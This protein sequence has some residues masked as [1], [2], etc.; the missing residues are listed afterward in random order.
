MRLRQPVALLTA[1]ACALP[2]GFAA[3]GTPEPKPV[4]VKDFSVRPMANLAYSDNRLLLHPKVLVGLGYD[5]NVYAETRDEN[6]GTFVRGLVGVL[7]DYRINPHQSLAIDGEFETKTYLKEENDEGDLIGGR[8]ALDYRWQEER[9]SAGLH[10]GYDRFNDPLIQTGEQVLRQ[11][12]DGN[13]SGAFSTSAILSVVRIGVV[14][15]DYLEDAA[16][17][18]EQSRDNN[19]I[20]ATLRI[21]YSEARDTF[22]YALIGYESVQYDEDT[23]FNSSNGV[24]GGVGLQV[25]LGER[26]SLTAEGGVTYRIYD[27]NFAGSTAWDDEEVLAPY[28]NIAARWP[29]EQGSH[30]GL[31]LFSR[32]DESITANAAWVYGGIFDGRL[33][34]AQHTGLF[35]SVSIYQSKDS[36]SGSGI[37]AEERTTQ[38]GQAGIEHE[39]RRG[40]VVR[41]KGTYTDSES[42]TATDFDR[43]VAVIEAAAAF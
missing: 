42:K 11:T 31:R 22:Y 13:L 33:R 38:E 19:E 17:F 37:Q 10:L 25:R 21:G 34:M 4:P 27:D 32:L 8:A 15:T 2:T 29:W 43:F 9:N 18:T 6:S 30:I 41:V 24:T 14:S 35:G 7:L 36:G 3:E 20:D 5:S 39:L 12:V 26:A 28:L 1:L 23:Q 40:V 16:Y